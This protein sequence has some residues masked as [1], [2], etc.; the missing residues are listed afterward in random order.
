M[1]LRDFNAM[2]SSKNG[3]TLNAYSFDSEANGDGEEKELAVFGKRQQLR[4]RSSPA[5]IYRT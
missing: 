1:K 2:S 5:N 4:A 3:T